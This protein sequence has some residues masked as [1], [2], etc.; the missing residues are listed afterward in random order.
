MKH[1]LIIIGAGPGGHQAALLAAHNGLQVLIVEQQHPGGTCLNAGCIPTKTLCRNA[2]VVSTI[3]QADQY[4]VVQN[5]FSIDFKAM[6]E[7]KQQVVEQLRNGM[8]SLL[9]NPAIEYLQGQAS[10]VD[11]HTIVVNDKQYTAPNI[12][13]ATGSVP[14][15][16][17]IPGI[18]QPNVLTSTEMLDI[19]SIPPTLA[20]VGAGVIGL[21]MASVFA[22]MG[23][24]VNVIEFLPECLPALD[25]D[26]AR[27]LRQT[28]SRQLPITFHLSSAV[29]AIDGESI[30]FEKKGKVVSI[31]AHTILIATGR[32]ASI[33]RL[34]LEHTNIKHSPKGIEVDD[35]M[36]TSVPGV[37]AVGDVNGRTMLAHAAHAQ[38]RRAV[39]H[40]L[41]RTDDIRLD[42]VPAAVF[43]HPE[44][45]SVGPT[46]QQLEQQGVAFVAKKV[47]FRANGKAL[48]D[49]QTEGILKL[50]A[51]AKGDDVTKGQRL[52]ACHVCGPHA[53]DIAQLVS[54]L[55]CRHTTVQQLLDI[56]LIHPTVTEILH[57]AAEQF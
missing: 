2:E 22:A 12:I 5:G 46:E 20:V 29:T 52:L 44:A 31:Q 6:Q 21:E 9:N 14:R 8:K 10:F 19:A 42:V 16:L 7:R 17:N 47:H 28:I 56:T 43:T 54:A 1:D 57:D 50:I 3:Q 39:N 51:E 11:D 38:A 15:M 13:I 4:G 55:I 53:A 27:R 24:E 48:A 32:Q 26:I 36:L 25:A 49:N 40:I 23:T 37:Y 35:N 18:N 34:G 41:H 45:A 33:G 30:H